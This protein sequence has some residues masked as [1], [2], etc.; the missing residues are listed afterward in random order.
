MTVST[1][2]KTI[3]DFHIYATPQDIPEELRAD[4]IETGAIRTLQL[5]L[6]TQIFPI[7]LTCPIEEY[8]EHQNTQ[9][10]QLLDDGRL[11]DFVFFHCRP[12]RMDILR[13]LMCDGAFGQ[14]PDTY[15]KIARRVW[16]DSEQDE[17]D[18]RWSLLL[19]PGLD[20][21]QALTST[22]DWKLLD[23]MGDRITIYRGVQATCATTALS[24]CLSGWS[25]TLSD[26]TARWFSRR[27]I[28]SAKE[29]F[30][31]QYEIPKSQV[32]AYLTDRGEE[33]IIVDPNLIERKEVQILS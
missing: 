14:S 32:I 3:I 21:R 15:W 10:R 25:W 6:L 11:M 18:E 31:A 29:A 7:A 1:T 13:N 2:P 12:F 16:M 22:R 20:G 24:E 26:R 8:L 33:E 23:G 5:P 30:V 17:N 28:P 4:V 19:N 9:S 27:R